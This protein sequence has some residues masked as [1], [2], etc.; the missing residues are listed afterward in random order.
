[1]RATIHHFLGLACSARYKRDW[2]ACIYPHYCCWGSD[3]IGVG[4]AVYGQFNSSAVGGQ[5]M[6]HWH[7]VALGSHCGIPRGYNVDNLVCTHCLHLRTLPCRYCIAR[8]C[9]RGPWQLRES[10]SSCCCL[11]CPIQTMQ[12]LRFLGLLGWPGLQIRFLWPAVDGVVVVVGV[13]VHNARRPNAS[14]Q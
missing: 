14:R 13:H 5:L 10:V 4:E 3:C 6:H 2:P 7:L 12:P 9:L 8:K 1:M 11:C